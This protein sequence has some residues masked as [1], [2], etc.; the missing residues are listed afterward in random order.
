[1]SARAGGRRH[2]PHPHARQQPVSSCCLALCAILHPASCPPPQPLPDHHC[3]PPQPLPGPSPPPLTLPTSC[4]QPPFTAGYQWDYV[5]DWTILKHAQN[6]TVPRALQTRP[7]T[8]GGSA[9]EGGGALGVCAIR[10]PLMPLSCPLLPS[11]PI[12]LPG[13]S[14][15]RSSPAEAEAGALTQAVKGVGAKATAAAC[16][17]HGRHLERGWGT[18]AEA[19]VWAPARHRCPGGWAAG[20]G[21][22]QL[23]RGRWASDGSTA[24]TNH[25]TSQLPHTQVTRGPRTTLRTWRACHGLSPSR[26]AS[27]AGIFEQRERVG[28]EGGGWRGGKLPG[29]RLPAPEACPVWGAVDRLVV[30]GG[31]EVRRGGDCECRPRHGRRGG[32]MQGPAA[33]A[34]A[35]EG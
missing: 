1:M 21:P 17:A 10:R 4:S 9:V 23:R 31:G 27:A 19:E 14:R 18:A 24:A 12:H 29:C 7:D 30:L 20:G 22:V 35:G 8:S 16:H 11:P 15:S 2:G 13:S 25:A 34:G 6:N 33:C 28:R 3:P 5:F 32:Q 26:R